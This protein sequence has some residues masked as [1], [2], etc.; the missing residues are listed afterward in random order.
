M[1][2]YDFSVKNGLGESV[3]LDIYRDH[4]ILIVNTAS[5]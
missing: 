2:I 1:S 3:S 5:A 4:V